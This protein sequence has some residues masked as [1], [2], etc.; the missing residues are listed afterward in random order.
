MP[1]STIITAW[2]INSEGQIIFD[3]TGENTT[4][5]GFLSDY[6]IP[7]TIDGGVACVGIAPRTNTVSVFHSGTGIAINTTDTVFQWNATQHDTQADYTAATGTFNLGKAGTYMLN[8]NFNVY[9]VLATEVF[10]WLQVS[11]DNGVSWSDIETSGRYLKTSVGATEPNSVPC[12][13]YTSTPIKL[14][15]VLKGST[16]SASIVQLPV[17]GTTTVYVPAS[18]ATLIYIG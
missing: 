17:I 11:T 16:T 9:T 4:P 7:T 6:S 13:V 5:V 8:L 12:T 10:M 18:K 3:P 2:P 1:V 14:R 15:V